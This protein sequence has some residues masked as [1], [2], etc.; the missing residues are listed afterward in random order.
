MNV[1]LALVKCQYTL[2]NIDNNK[3]VSRTFED[4]LKNIDG[5]LFLSMTTV[6]TNKLKKDHFYRTTWSIYVLW[7]RQ[8]SCEWHWWRL[9]L[10]EQHDTRRISSKYGHALNFVVSTKS[11]AE[12][13]HAGS[14][15]PQETRT[16]RTHAIHV[17]YHKTQSSENPEKETNNTTK[18]CFTATSWTVNRGDVRMRNQSLLHIVAGKRKKNLKTSMLRFPL[19]MRRETT[20]GHQA[21]GMLSSHVDSITTLPVSRKHFFFDQNRSF[22]FTMELRCKEA[23]GIANTTKTLSYVRR[24][25]SCVLSWRAP[26]SSESNV[27]AS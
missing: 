12:F 9:T 13:C 7:L 21:Q 11:K 18:S 4:H 5:V 10:S 3:I 17:S 8:D 24:F 23:Y 22:I 25:W 1:I 15:P 26:S 2:F 16:R 20:L 27:S 19:V 14:S 6:V